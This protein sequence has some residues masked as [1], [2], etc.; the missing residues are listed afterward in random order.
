MEY[1]EIIV[2]C[3]EDGTQSEFERLDLISYQN[4]QYAV[5]MALGKDEG[6][7]VILQ[8]E[9]SSVRGEFLYDDVEDEQVLLAVFDQ[10][11]ALHKDEFRFSQ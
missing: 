6:D 8:A 5:L 4:R 10:F 1:R 9:P 2:L 3:D 7:L 11:K